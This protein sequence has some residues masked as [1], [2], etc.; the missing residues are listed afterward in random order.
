MDGDDAGVGAAT[1]DVAAH[2]FAHIGVGRPAGLLEQR[3]RGHDLAGRAIA[4]LVAIVR[5]EGRLHGMQRPGL[6]DAFDRGDL[7]ALV[8]YG[9]A[10]AG[11]HPHAVDM[12]GAGAALAVVAAFLRAGEQDDFTHA[13][14]KRGARVE[15]QPMLISVDA[16]SQ[17]YGTLG[18]RG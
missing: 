17:G 6:S 7:V 1:T 13:V 14:Q 3:D 16:Q 12:H 4:A 11:V 9:E 18:S 2:A 8:H 5:D 15:A 10:Q